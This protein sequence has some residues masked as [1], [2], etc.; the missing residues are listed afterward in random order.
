M[1]KRNGVDK[2]RGKFRVIVVITVIVI[3]EAGNSRATHVPN[4]LH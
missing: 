2:E 4:A 3:V 1:G